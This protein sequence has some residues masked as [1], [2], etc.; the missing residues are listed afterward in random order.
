M[1]MSVKTLKGVI[2]IVDV[3][4]TYIVQVC[5]DAK[6]NRLEQKIDLSTLNIRLA[7]EDDLA[8]PGIEEV[9]DAV[10]EFIEKKDASYAHS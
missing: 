6:S 3:P 10:K 2:Y 8:S 5:L 7:R 9:N 1:C 4:H